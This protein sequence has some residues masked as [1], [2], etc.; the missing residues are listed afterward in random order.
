VLDTDGRAR[1]VAVT[2]LGTAEI[3]SS[4]TRFQEGDTVHLAVDADGVAALDERLATGPEGG[5]R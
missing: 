5:H 4:T 3:P 2:R 1:V